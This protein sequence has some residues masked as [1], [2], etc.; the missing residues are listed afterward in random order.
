MK[1]GGILC[2]LALLVSGCT[3]HNPMAPTPAYEGFAAEDSAVV[4]CGFSAHILAIDDDDQLD[5]KPLEGRFALKPGK[6]T[7]TIRLDAE[8][9]G[10]GGESAEPQ[11]VTF[12]LQAGHTYD[13]SAFAQPVA[14]KDW[15]L[16]VTN[17]TTGE[18]LINPYS[19]KAA[20]RDPL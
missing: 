3:V 19:P 17:R 14:G 18:D 9:P 1:R 13:I 10:S 7:F 6:H 11:Q 20:S 2:G 4:E 15:A 16:V 12:R 5:C 8:A